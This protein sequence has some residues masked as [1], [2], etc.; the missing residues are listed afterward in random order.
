M[1]CGQI[2]VNKESNISL[3]NSRASTHTSSQQHM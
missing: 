2:A 1:V 3:M